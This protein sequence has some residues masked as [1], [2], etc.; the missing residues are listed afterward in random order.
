MQLYYGWVNDFIAKEYENWYLGLDWCA[1]L[2]SRCNGSNLAVG[3][4][5]IIS[6]IG[7]IFRDESNSWCSFWVRVRENKLKVLFH[8]AS[9]SCQRYISDSIK[10]IK[11]FIS[12]KRVFKRERKSCTCQGYVEQN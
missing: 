12:F 9:L 2:V 6:G 11:A 5:C 8:F 4:L 10:V 7:C 3:L 1:I